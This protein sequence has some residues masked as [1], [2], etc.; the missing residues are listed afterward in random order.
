MKLIDAILLSL[1]VGFFIIGLHQIMH[2]GFQNGY[3]AVMLST[4]LFFALI[5]RK[6]SSQKTINDPKTMKPKKKITK[7]D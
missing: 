6:T 2:L 7:K 3:W 1:S 5:Y 4:V